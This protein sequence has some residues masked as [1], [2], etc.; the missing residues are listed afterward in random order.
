MPTTPTSSIST[1]LAS[2]NTVSKNNPSTS[3]PSTSSVPALDKAFQILDLITSS[4]SPLTAADIAKQLGLAR[5]ST[6]SIL[7][8][9]LQKGVLYKDSQHHFYLGSYLLHWAGK[10]EHQQ[11]VTRFFQELIHH[12]P[13]LLEQTITLSTLDWDKGEVVY[14]ACYESPAPLG[15]AFRVGLRLPAVF[16]AT[17]K[18]ILSTV[19]M[20]IIQSIYADGLPPP[21]TRHS[22]SNFENLAE[23]LTVTKATR[24]SLDNGQIREGMYCVGTYIKD[25]SGKAIAGIA[26]SFLQAEYEQKSKETAIALVKFAKE[27]QQCMGYSEI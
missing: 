10:Y 4:T 14:L 6:H 25:A 22:V 27:I 24:L 9:L 1:E 19:N 11:Q 16:S 12:H 13:L 20:P 2:T 7:Q 5:S 26:V 17:G 8:S 15:F 3:N 18:A 23:E 21:L